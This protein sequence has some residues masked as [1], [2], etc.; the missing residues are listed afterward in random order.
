VLLWIKKKVAS[1][2]KKS[3]KKP[4][5][6]VVTQDIFRASF[7]SLVEALVKQCP[8][9]IL[10]EIYKYL[11]TEYGGLKNQ[12]LSHFA[13]NYSAKEK[14]K[15]WDRVTKVYNEILHPLIETVN[16]LESMES[17]THKT[18]MNTLNHAILTYQKKDSVEAQSAISNEILR[19]INPIEINFIRLK[20][21]NDV[22]MIKCKIGS[23]T[24]PYAMV[25]TGS[26]TSIITENIARQL[27]FEIDKS[28]VPK[29]TGVASEAKAIGSI[30]NLPI[31]IGYGEDAITIP[32]EFAV[33]K[34]E[35]NK[36]LVLLG[37]PWLHRA[38]WEP[39]VK[40]EFKASYNGKDITIPLS[41]HKAQREV[42]IAESRSA[43]SPEI[44]QEIKKN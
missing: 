36:P 40:G 15:V 37:I 25:D 9:E 26:N 11:N 44:K 42:F 16:R 30:Y 41:V 32:D 35:K 17:E 27:G 43:L 39:I 28:N 12:L 6:D 31:T 4:S 22:A 2:S 13:T 3:K 8:I 21:P 7:K 5:I 14:E 23:M 10:V 34:D 33:V 38:G 20:S 29:I 24:I 19:W 18:E 1:D